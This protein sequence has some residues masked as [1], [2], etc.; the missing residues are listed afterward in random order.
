MKT[1]PSLA[2]LAILVLAGPLRADLTLTQQLDQPGEKKPLTITTKIQGAMLRSELSPEMSV[3]MDSRSGE[4]TTL[5]HSQKM[6]MKVP[7]GMIKAAQA[8]AMS[9]LPKSDA[10]PVPTGRTETIN[11]FKCQEY[12][13][14][15]DGK[16]VEVWVTD[17]IPD[18]SSIMSQLAMLSA[19]ANPLGDILKGTEITGFPIRTQ[20]GMG[21]LGKVTMTI[22]SLNRADLPASDFEVPKSYKL[23]AVPKI[24]GLQ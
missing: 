23:M 8:A 21:P 18:A 20:V 11:G 3:I 13:V 2:S 15:Q 14:A 7:G 19:D 12:T 1:F 17:E 6:A 24:P 22:V 5:L 4:T 10:K 9:N 16:T